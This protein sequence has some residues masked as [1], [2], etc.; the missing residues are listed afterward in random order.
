[1]KIDLSLLTGKGIRVDPAGDGHYGSARGDRLHNGEDYLCDEG[2]V[3]RA[4]FNMLI[5]RV[6]NP[7]AN[8]P[9]SGIK[10]KYGKSEGKIFYF[11]PKLSLVGTMVN[12]GTIIGTAQSCSFH[13]GDPAML[14]HIHFQIDK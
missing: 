11:E 13:Y 14:D 1:M 7:S 10:W 8:K 3:V 6:A 9:L 5:E 12:K 4:P 2:Q